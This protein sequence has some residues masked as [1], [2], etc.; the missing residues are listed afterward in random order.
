MKRSSADRRRRRRGGTSLSDLASA[1]GKHPSLCGSLYDHAKVV[2]EHEG[3]TAE[4]MRSMQP[5]LVQ[6]SVKLIQSPTEMRDFLEKLN[7]DAQWLKCGS[8]DLTDLKDQAKFDQKLYSL[9]FLMADIKRQEVEAIKGDQQAL[10]TY[11]TGK[12]AVFVHH[13]E[14]CAKFQDPKSCQWMWCH[15]PNRVQC[16][17]LW[18]YLPNGGLN[19]LSY[20]DFDHPLPPLSI[21]DVYPWSKDRYVCPPR[22]AGR[23][24]P[25]VYISRKLVK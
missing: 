6:M 8:M 17:M 15:L 2:R 4:F 21:S 9:L 1:C 16:P 3:L 20:G 11:V 23:F 7:L 10:E 19:L 22:S 12:L 18:A 24:G 13:Y 14:R 25:V 5:I